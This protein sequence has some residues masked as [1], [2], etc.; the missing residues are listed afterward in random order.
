M[1]GSDTRFSQFHRVL[2]PDKVLNH[3]RKAWEG[4]LMGKAYLYTFSNRTVDALAERLRQL[5]KMNDDFILMEL[6]KS[7]CKAEKRR[8]ARNYYHKKAAP[9]LLK[10]PVTSFV[11]SWLRLSTEQHGLAAP[12]LA[13]AKRLKSALRNVASVGLSAQQ[14]TSSGREGYRTYK[15]LPVLTEALSYQSSSTTAL[16]YSLA[17]RVAF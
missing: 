5:W 11:P 4:K 6:L 16:S 9:Y 8:D 17:R 3:K 14:S 15:S 10:G 7:S 12:P 2:V 13:E 1:V